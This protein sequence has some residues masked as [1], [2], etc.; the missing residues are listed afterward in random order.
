MTIEGHVNGTGYS[1]KYGG[2][3]HSS[4]YGWGGH[5]ESNKKNTNKSTDDFSHVGNG[6]VPLAASLY[7]SRNDRLVKIDGN[8]IIQCVLAGEKAMA[9][10]GSAD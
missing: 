3:D 7:I 9:F 8:F 6:S 2:K 1:V 5:G 10:H 4:H